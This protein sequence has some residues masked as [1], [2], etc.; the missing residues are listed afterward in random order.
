MKVTR[1]EQ[2]VGAEQQYVIGRVYK[3]DYV[4]L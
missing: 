4:G 1:G 2:N 3:C